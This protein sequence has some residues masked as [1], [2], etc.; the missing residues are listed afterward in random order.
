MVARAVSQQEHVKLE[1]TMS[2]RRLSTPSY[3]ATKL[4]TADQYVTQWRWYYEEGGS[5][6]LFGMVCKSSNKVKMNNRDKL[7]N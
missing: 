2:V 7:N 3:V 4:T 6:N 1:L 5:W